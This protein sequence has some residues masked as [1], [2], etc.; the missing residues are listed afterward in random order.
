MATRATRVSW[1]DSQSITARDTTS[2][3]ALP[4]MMGRKA[5]SPCISPTS[6][7][8][9]D[10]SWPVCSLSWLPK[11]SRWSRSNTALRR[12]NCTSRLTRPPTNRRM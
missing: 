5:R 3:T 4:S 2:I 11:S 6:L 9:R 8:A 10:T 7:E 12:S 1:G